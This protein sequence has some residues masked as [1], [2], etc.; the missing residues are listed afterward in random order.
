MASQ[1][2]SS[3]CRT[4]LLVLVLA[5]TTAA[6]TGDFPPA[7][8]RPTVALI[9]EITAPTYR[10]LLQDTQ[11]QQ[12]CRQLQQQMESELRSMLR[13]RFGFVHWHTG[14]PPPGDTAFMRLMQNAGSSVENPVLE[15]L[16]RRGNPGAARTL[17]L[18]FEKWA[19]AMQRTGSDPATLRTAWLQ[20]VEAILESKGPQAITE[21]L[22]RVPVAAAVTPDWSALKAHVAVHRDTIGA[23][24]SPRPEFLL[25]I[26]IRDTAPFPTVDTAGLVLRGCVSHATIGYVCNMAEVISADPN[27]PPAPAEGLKNRAEVKVVSVHLRQYWARTVVTAP[28]GA[29]PPGGT[30]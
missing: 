30:E 21:Y 4:L 11:C 8:M 27:I 9:F 10:A 14:G 7:A 6:A 13:G 16:V 3:S 25:R 12:A 18:D 1:I 2:W 23:A 17:P 29:I 26:A 24:E 5:T 22:G 19:D 28:G 15:L 20:K